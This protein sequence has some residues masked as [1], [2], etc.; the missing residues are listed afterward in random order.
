MVKYVLLID[1]IVHR[2]GIDVK[3]TDLI[4]YF[5]AILVPCYA[6]AFLIVWFHSFQ[7]LGIFDI[8]MSII[9]GSLFSLW[10]WNMS[11][12]AD[13]SF[14]KFSKTVIF[15]I[16]IIIAIILIFQEFQNNSPA[17]SIKDILVTAAIIAAV[18]I[19]SHFFNYYHH[20]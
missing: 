8:F 6:M 9:L 13:K 17:K 19:Y 10:I 1:L 3:K 15:I 20:R 18:F 2:E 12:P 7:K 14:D 16:L 5:I 11:I 4:F